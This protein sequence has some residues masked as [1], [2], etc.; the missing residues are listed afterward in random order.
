[1]SCEPEFVGDRRYLRH[2]A[3]ETNGG[4]LIPAMDG[5]GIAAAS[6]RESRERHRVAEIAQQQHRLTALKEHQQK[7]ARINAM[8]AGAAEIP[9]LPFREQR[10]RTD[11]DGTTRYYFVDEHGKLL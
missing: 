6:A 11:R 4:T 8:Y 5:Y 9:K 2:N 10:C 1:M 7:Q 3:W